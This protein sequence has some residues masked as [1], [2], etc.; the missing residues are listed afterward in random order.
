MDFRLHYRGPLRSNGTA[1]QQQAIRRAFHPQLATLWSQPPLDRYTGTFLDA[2]LGERDTLL[3]RVG[4]FLFS[5][6]VSSRLGLTA[7]I[8]ILFLRHQRAGAIVGTG[9]DIDNRLKTLFDALSVPNSDQIAGDNPRADEEPF[10][11]LLDDD[12][13]ITKV[14]VTTDQWLEPTAPDDVILVLHVTIQDRKAGPTL[15]SFVD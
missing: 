8:D 3:R 2:T 5:A 15:W 12:V 10:H 13:L 7:D 1:P 14:A 9:G 11:C 4:P 6:L